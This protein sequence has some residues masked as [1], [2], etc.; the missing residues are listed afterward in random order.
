MRIFIGILLFFSVTTFAKGKGEIV[1][2]K[3]QAILGKYEINVPTD[4]ESLDSAELRISEDKKL[5]LYYNNNEYELTGPDK[6]GVV[7]S[8]D[9]EPNCDGDEPTCYYDVHTTVW[10][11]SARVKGKQTYQLQVEIER[12]DAFD[13]TGKSMSTE[14]YTLNW[15]E[16]LANA[17]PFFTRA[18]APNELGELMENCNKAV[19]PTVGFG[20]SNSNDI[21][22]FNSTFKYRSPEKTAIRELIKF[23]S[24]RNSKV[25]KITAAQLQALVFD[26]NE[27]IIKNLDDKKIKVPVKDLLAEARKVQKIILKYSDW[28]YAK[29][30]GP[31]AIVYSVNR[32]SRTVVIY[33]IDVPYKL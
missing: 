22:T 11:K 13:E 1:D 18:N 16:E 27:E 17:I 24:G 30:K 29:T 4:D 20:V 6:N 5:T 28:I 33:H 9:D 15:S 2:L 26:K 31:S 32:A 12:D 3:D 8:G 7:Y 23:Y 14:Y 25:Q 21:C 19:E 10:L